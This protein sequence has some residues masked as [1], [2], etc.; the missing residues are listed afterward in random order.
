VPKPDSSQR[1]NEL[2]ADELQNVRKIAFPTLHQN[3][4]AVP[5]YGKAR[6]APSTSNLQIR[7]PDK[8]AGPS[9]FLTGLKEDFQIV[10][11]TSNNA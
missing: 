10:P 11:K 7:H 2:K 8:D 1:L 4:L 9:T 5:T 3:Q 6:N